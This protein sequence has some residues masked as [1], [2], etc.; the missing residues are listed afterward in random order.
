MDGLLAQCGEFRI[1]KTSTGGIFFE[2]LAKRTPAS[3]M[4]ISCL[5]LRLSLVSG[6]LTPIVR[7]R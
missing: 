6:I 2:I 5:A 1:G 3:I 4:L 7:K